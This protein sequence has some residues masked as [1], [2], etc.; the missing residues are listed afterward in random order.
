MYF[1]Q[2]MGRQASRNLPGC[3]TIA[4]VGKLVAHI[5][6]S[7]DKKDLDKGWRYDHIIIRKGVRGGRTKYHGAYELVNGKLKRVETF[8]DI[9]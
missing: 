2:I 6:E 8:A 5:Y 4:E 7:W 3:R 9:F 1:A